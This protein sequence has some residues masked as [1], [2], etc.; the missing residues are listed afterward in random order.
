MKSLFG[1]FLRLLGK[2]LDALFSGLIS[3]IAHLIQLV[4]QIRSY[5]AP[6]FTCLVMAL[7]SMPLLI[8]V[9]PIVRL[10]GW[11]WAIIAILLFFPLLG[12]GFVSMLEYGKYVL[13]EFLFD[14]ADYYTSGRGAKKSF[15]S[16]GAAYRRKL[17]EEEMAR[18]REAQQREKERW[19]RIFSSYFG[20][21]SGP[22]QGGFYQ[23]TTH[24]Q[25]G[26]SRAGQQA[27]GGYQGMGDPVA[28]FKEKVQKSC[29][30]LG[31]TPNATEYEL[32]LAYRKLAKKFHPDLN[33]EPYATRR[34][35][36]INDAYEFLSRENLERYRR[37]Q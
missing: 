4:Q 27:S 11:V 1:G 29:Q 36:E 19:D 30:I 3:L 16:Y 17:W 7:L 23:Q 2:G 13:T 32:K 31:V 26:Y 15:S 12:R 20:G 33:K 18:R 24:G 10:P 25:G 21:F 6:I 9:L 14:Q 8:F 35:Q 5:F 22:F 34:F 28:D 37:F